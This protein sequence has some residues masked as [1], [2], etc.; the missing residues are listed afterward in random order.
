MDYSLKEEPMKHYVQERLDRKKR[1]WKEKSPL[2]LV[3]YFYQ[4]G[5]ILQK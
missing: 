4:L 5:P 3:T 2:E 1:E